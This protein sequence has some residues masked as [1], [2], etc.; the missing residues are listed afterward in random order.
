MPSAHNQLTE[1]N[2]DPHDQNLGNTITDTNPIVLDDLDVTI[3]FW[4]GVRS[5]TTPPIADFV[6]YEKLSPQFWAFTTNLSNVDISRDIHEELQHPNWKA[7]MQEEIRALEKNG[8]SE[9][10]KIAYGKIYYRMQVDF[11]CET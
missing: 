9:F 1:P 8:T 2:L 5:C 3:A 7:A 11:Q 4:K 6:S 10:N